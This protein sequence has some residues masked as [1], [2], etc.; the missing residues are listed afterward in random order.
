MRYGAK[1]DGCM[2][3]NQK[4]CVYNRFCFEVIAGYIYEQRACKWQLYYTRFNSYLI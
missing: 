3:M 2:Y 4:S 1:N